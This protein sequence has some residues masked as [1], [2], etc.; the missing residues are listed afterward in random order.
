MDTSRK[1]AVAPVEALQLAE[2][3]LQVAKLP[4]LAVG[5]AGADDT[6]TAKVRA[7]LVPQAL[8]AVTLIFPF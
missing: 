7:I 1:Y 5:E 6:V 8:P 3:E 2:N 4:A